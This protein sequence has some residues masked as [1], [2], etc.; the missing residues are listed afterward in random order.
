MLAQDPIPGEWQGQQMKSGPSGCN[1]SFFLLILPFVQPTMPLLCSFHLLGLV[2]S[3][4]SIEGKAKPL[5]H[6]STLQLFQD[7]YLMSSPLQAKALKKKKKGK[8]KGKKI[9]ICFKGI[10]CTSPFSFQVVFLL[11]AL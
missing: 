4:G 6:M 7:I 11:T 10:K 3:L 5:F 2:L 9:P 8:A 1:S